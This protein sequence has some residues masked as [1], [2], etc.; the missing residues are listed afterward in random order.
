MSISRPT[1]PL[2]TKWGRERSD[3]PKALFPFGWGE[4]F[5]EGLGGEGAA[6]RAARGTIGEGAARGA[7]RLI[8]H[9]QINQE[10]TK[11]HGY[12]TGTPQ[13]CI[14]QGVKYAVHN[15]LGHIGEEREH[16]AANNKN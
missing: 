7:R 10:K 15:G 2:F 5:G 9:T 4:G 16:Q 12:K 1:T 8:G 11:A 13:Q 6:R 14:A 3:A